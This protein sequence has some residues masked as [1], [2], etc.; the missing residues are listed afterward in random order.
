MATKYQRNKVWYVSYVEGGKRVRKA[1]GRD[2]KTAELIRQDIEVKQAKEGSGLFLPQISLDKFQCEYF[3]FLETNLRPRTVE[4]CEQII[5]L[6]FDYLK[7]DQAVIRLS[8]ISPRIIEQYKA[9]RLK[10]VTLNTLKVPSDSSGPYT[11][12]ASSS[13]ILSLRSD[14][15][16]LML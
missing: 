15:K 14:G 4:K 8:E 6:F 9:W 11:D 3:P 1:V 5:K 13:S 2:K 7:Q 16:L 10:Q 12:P